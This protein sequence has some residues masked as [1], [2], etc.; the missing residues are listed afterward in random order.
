MSFDII[1][2]PGSTNPDQLN[3]W[4]WYA[5]DDQ[6]ARVTAVT[7]GATANGQTRYKWVMWTKDGTRYE[8]GDDVWNGSNSGTT[9]KW[10]L[11][12]ITDNTGNTITYANA[13]EQKDS[14]CAT[15][16]DRFRP[17]ARPQ[18][19][20]WANNGYR[21]VFNASPRVAANGQGDYQHDG[22]YDMEWDEEAGPECGANAPQSSNRPH[23]T[24][25]LDSVDVQVNVGGTWQ[26]MRRYVFT[27]D[28][29][30]L[31]SDNSTNNP[32][33]KKLALKTIT[34]YG[35]DNVTAQPSMILTYNSTRGAGTYPNGGWNRLI[36]ADNG[37]GGVV[38]FTYE[39]IGN[40]RGDTLF[41]NNNR[42]TN[43][44]RSDG[45]G[46]NYDWGYSYGTPAYNSRGTTNG[47]RGPLANPSAADVYFARYRNNSSG[48]LDA[49][50]HRDE[51]TFLGHEQVTET[52]PSGTQTRHWFYRGDTGKQASYANGNTWSAGCGYPGSPGAA[53]TGA[54]IASNGCFIALRDAMFFKGREYLTQ[55]LVS[56]R[57]APLRETEH[58]FEIYQPSKPNTGAVVQ[59]VDYT[60]AP[61]R[62]LWGRFAF[63]R[64]QIES[65]YESA[66]S[67]PHSVVSEYTYDHDQTCNTSCNTNITVP[68]T[69]PPPR[70][71][72][73]SKVTTSMNGTTM[74]F[75]LTYFLVG[76]TASTYRVDRVKEQSRFLLGWS[77]Q[78]FTSYE[79]D[80]VGRVILERSW[81]S[82]ASLVTG[83][84]ATSRDT[85]Y[86]YDTWGNQQ[87][88]TTYTDR[89]T[90]T[91]TTGVGWAYSSAGN[92]SAA[93]AVTTTAYDSTYHALVTQITDPLGR[94]TK[95]EWDYQRGTLLKVL[96]P[97]SSSGTGTLCTVSGSYS[98][99]ATEETTCAQYDSFGRMALLVK[100]GDSTSSPTVYYSY[101]NYGGTTTTPFRYLY[102]QR[103]SG[104]GG[105]LLRETVQ[106]YDGMGRLIQ[107]KQESQGFGAQT[108][109][110]DT[111]FD[112]LDRATA[113]SQAR[114][115]TESGSSWDTYT[116]PSSPLYRPTTTT[117]EVGG[118]VYD[119]TDP[120]S[121]T[122]STRYTYGG[123]GTVAAV[124]DTNGHYSTRETDPLGRMIK[125]VE[126]SGISG[127]DYT[128]TYGYN[129]RNDLT[130]VNDALGN[131]TT[132]VYT[133]TVS[134]K[135]SMADQ[136]LG[137]WTYRYDAARNLS[138]Q[139]DARG[140]VTTLGYDALDQVLD[141]SFSDG[142]AAAHWRYDDTSGGNLGKGH[143]T[144]S[145]RGTLGACSVSRAWVYD[146][147]GR[148]TNE[149]LS[150][151][152]VTKNQTTSYDSADRVVGQTLP[153]GEALTL[154]FDGGWRP[155]TLS[156]TVGYVT[157]A[158]YTA[159]D[160]PT[161]R[162]LGNGLTQEWGY[163]SPLQRLSQIN[164][165]VGAGATTHVKLNYT[166]D[167]VGNILTMNEG[168]TGSYPGVITN[169]WNQTFT[170][171]ERDRLKTAQ[172][173]TTTL[174]TPPPSYASD[175]FSRT[176]SNGMGGLRIV[177][178]RGRRWVGSPPTIARTA[179]RVSSVCRLRTPTAKYGLRV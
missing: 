173:Q 37:Q 72:N 88:V 58:V 52:D 19:I 144:S 68:A 90:A 96:G 26:Q 111:T 158:Q 161:S 36:S 163:S 21:V 109:V 6:F 172:A 122:T 51:R 11:T 120:D 62:G 116:S 39:N 33:Y 114:Y 47:G 71:G 151:G 124:T 166:Y 79:Y 17:N 107:S 15:T 104:G 30:L 18:T 14:H 143:R 7:N 156:G 27:Y 132:I 34:Q 174:I 60:S 8:F 32:A 24:R 66:T 91:Y 141:M 89:G 130:S 142:T 128:T 168:A 101:R 145:C 49:L 106:F 103:S 133:P 108:I 171:D 129:A 57:T 61:L 25:K 135:T 55:V 134:L 110:T 63:E 1:R 85:S 44:R 83:T 80:G 92:G 45:R 48:D 137:T 29:S 82:P 67:S 65:T 169:H 98:I 40:A 126:Q 167:A 162:T 74:W 28:L 153:N 170:Y 127:T 140:I 78:Q 69:N 121:K 76:E 93:R 3:N 119:V 139:T 9:Y 179:A 59:D 131:A 123:T 50:L 178:V 43:I 154:T 77:L 94:V 23:E 176:V 147:R 13:Y 70:Y 86:G 117:Y 113:Q 4:S 42:V 164:V 152:G 35:S 97:N 118:R 105:D 149:T 148:A 160:Q 5:A 177:V 56:G 102:Q 150:A 16:N 136:D 87:T 41:I 99:P 46:T 22:N 73:R 53:L 10:W 38:T 31:I 146:A 157:A 81:D 95:G 84:K 115:V 100:S 112:G 175:T 155:Q 138:S 20:T 159:L 54:A 75:D 165:G 125:V 64:R 12:S 2:G